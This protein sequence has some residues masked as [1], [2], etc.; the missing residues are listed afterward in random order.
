MATTNFLDMPREV[1]DMIY[2]HYTLIDGGYKYNPDTGKL[3]PATPSQNHLAL[4]STCKLLA[5]EMQ[6]LAVANNVVSFSTVENMRRQAFTFDLLCYLFCRYEAELLVQLTSEGYVSGSTWE[7]MSQRFPAFVT[8][9]DAIKPHIPSVPD[10]P[11]PSR[12]QGRFA[13]CLCKWT[14]IAMSLKRDFIHTFLKQIGSEVNPDVVNLALHERTWMVPSDAEIAAMSD[15]IKHGLDN[16]LENPESKRLSR[17]LSRIKESNGPPDTDH[18]KYYFSAAAVAIRFLQANLTLAHHIRKLVL[19]EDNSAVADSE[20]H[21]RGLIPFCVRNPRLRIERRLSLWTNVFFTTDRFKKE[22]FS[23]WRIRPGPSWIHEA[24][25]LPPAIS[26]I[27]DGSPAAPEICS[28]N[29]KTV[30]VQDALLQKGVEESYRRELLSYPGLLDWITGT[31]VDWTEYDDEDY[32]GYCCENWPEIVKNILD[33]RSPISCNF[34][35]ENTF[36]EDF[37]DLMRRA[38]EGDWCHDDWNDLVEYQEPLEPDLAPP[39]WEAHMKRYKACRD[40]PSGR[41]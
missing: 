22:R 21:A 13:E 9:M 7:Y 23:N 41:T 40:W 6:G 14:G 18:F 29:F 10:T 31:T 2:M 16:D 26:L 38:E 32:L 30:L 4:Q 35:P 24:L 33:G 20:T 28:A 27:L 19:Y 11:H 15:I 12:T 1:R 3:R 34:A 17:Y 39:G 5:R 25:L 36:D 37:E 8:H